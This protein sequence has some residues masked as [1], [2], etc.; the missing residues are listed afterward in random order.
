MVDFNENPRFARPSTLIAAFQRKIEE[1]VEAARSRN[2]PLG[3]SF[4]AFFCS[5]FASYL[6]V[7]L[8]PLKHAINSESRLY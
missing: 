4:L 6:A 7:L 1:L 5:P 3:V 8:P 2:K